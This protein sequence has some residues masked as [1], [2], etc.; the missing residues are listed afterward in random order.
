MIVHSVEQESPEWR[1]L[2]AGIPCASDFSKLII[3]TG[4]PSKSPQ[5]YAITLAAEK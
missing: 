3:R 2:R 5:A 4:Q 1:A